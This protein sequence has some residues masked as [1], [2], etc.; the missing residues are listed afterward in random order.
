MIEGLTAVLDMLVNVVMQILVVF[1]NIVME[2]ADSEAGKQIMGE[3]SY[4]GEPAHQT[5]SV[6]VEA[7]KAFGVDKALKFAIPVLLI[8]LFFP[9]MNLLKKGR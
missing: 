6:S 3:G 8:F 9:K 7:M 2:F 1:G 5:A 4:P